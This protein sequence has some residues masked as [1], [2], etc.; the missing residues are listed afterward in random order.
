MTA[1]Q[2]PAPPLDPEPAD[3]TAPGDELEHWLTGL[4]TDLATDPPDWI[5]TDPGGAHPTSE[6]DTPGSPKPLPPGQPESSTPVART[7]GRHRSPD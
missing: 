6:P 7:V 2:D 3:A 4:R 5:N 1:T